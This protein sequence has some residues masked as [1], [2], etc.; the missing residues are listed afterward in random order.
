MNFLLDTCVFLDPR[1]KNRLTKEDD[2]VMTPMDEI[3]VLSETERASRVERFSEDDSMPLRKK[4]NLVQYY[5][6]PIHPIPQELMQIMCTCSI[7][8][9]V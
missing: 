7:Q 4:D 9:L 2:T 3:V 6:V 5:L 1:F 8:V